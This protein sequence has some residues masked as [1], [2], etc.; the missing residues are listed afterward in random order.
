MNAYLWYCFSVANLCSTLCYPM[1]YRTPGFPV[2]HYLLEFTQTH[3]HWVS[4]NLHANTF[5]CLSGIQSY[6]DILHFTGS[7][8]HWHRL[9]GGWRFTLFLGKGWLGALTADDGSA[10]LNGVVIV[11]HIGVAAQVKE[12][13]I[14]AV[15]G[16]AA[17]RG[18]E[19]RVGRR[20]QAWPLSRWPWALPW[21]S[22]PIPHE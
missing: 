17:P 13:L 7:P 10:V 19:G 5:H 14:A 22:V 21:S 1:D 4:V 6:W 12:L 15:V 3:V 9:G 16:M 2:L 20:G 8:A 11:V 18:R